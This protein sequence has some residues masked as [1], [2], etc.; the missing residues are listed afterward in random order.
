MFSAHCLILVYFSTQFHE[1]IFDGYRAD[2]IFILIISK[3][4]KSAKDVDEL[5]FFFYAHHLMTLNIY[6]KFHKNI[7]D[8]IKEIEWTQFCMKNF[9][10]E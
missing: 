2:I 7:L 4:H 5:S 10:G 1:N 6:T 3:G 9:N 8:R